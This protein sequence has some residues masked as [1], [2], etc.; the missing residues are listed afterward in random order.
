MAS[1]A[2][3]DPML[4]TTLGLESG[5][6]GVPD[7][8]PAG[9]Q[10]QD[11][12]ARTTLARLNRL[13]SDAPPGPDGERRCA[14]LLRE[15]LETALAVSATGERLRRPQH[16][17]TGAGPAGDVHADAGQERPTG[18]RSRSGSALVPEALAGYTASLREGMARRLVRALAPGGRIQAQLQDWGAAGGR[19]WF[20]QFCAAAR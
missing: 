15:R 5:A 14:R 3:L 7:L 2:D 17:R 1:L 18:R 8:S 16:P 12:L 19:G 10:A 4:A 20:A 11:E 13:T 6:Q 9:Y